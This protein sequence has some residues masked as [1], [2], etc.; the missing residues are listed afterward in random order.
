MVDDSVNVFLRK[1]F[2][3]KLINDFLTTILL[4]STTWI[5]I[6]NDVLCMYS[7]TYI[8][9]S[10]KFASPPSLCWSR[11]RGESLS[12]PCIPCIISF[13]PASD[14]VSVPWLDISRIAKTRDM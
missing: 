1:Y 9:G 7:K 10:L 13:I 4:I 5:K 14:P 8:D 12:S 2:L 11:G 6:L 3:E